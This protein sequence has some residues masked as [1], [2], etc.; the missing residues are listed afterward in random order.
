MSGMIDILAFEKSYKFRCDWC[1]RE[2]E[3]KVKWE[4][5]DGMAMTDFSLPDSW[6]QAAFASPRVVCS[7]DCKAERIEAGRRARRICMERLWEANKLLR[8]GDLPEGF[9][10]ELERLRLKKM[11]ERGEK[12]L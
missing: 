8:E 3:K 12:F 7:A 1:K 11:Q 2:T 9:Y 10:E 4:D 6:V 5:E